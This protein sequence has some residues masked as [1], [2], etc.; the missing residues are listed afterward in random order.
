[1]SELILN[2]YSIGVF[3]NRYMF[4]TDIVANIGL[5][6]HNIHCRFISPQTTYSYLKVKTKI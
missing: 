1:M 6:I 3:I 4:Y 5:I 2:K